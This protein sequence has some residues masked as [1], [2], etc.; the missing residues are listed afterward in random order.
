MVSWMKTYKT[1]MYPTQEQIIKLNQTIGVCRFL[2]NQFISYNKKMYEKEGK[3]VSGM[4]FDK[5]VNN[6]LSTQEGFEWIKQAY[7]KARKKSIMN[8]EHAF[9][10]FF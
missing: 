3:F 9:K 8:A 5:Y 7:G 6:E 4:E 10:R 2:Y 1:E